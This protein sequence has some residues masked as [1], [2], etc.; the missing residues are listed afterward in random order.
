MTRFGVLLAVL[1]IGSLLLPMFD[2]QF[3]IMSL[4]EDFQPV[5]GIVVTVIG[6]VLVFL[7]MRSAQPAA[8]PPSTTEPPAA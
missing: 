3:T 7:G 1:G 5:A 6:A 2:I 8:T 4:V